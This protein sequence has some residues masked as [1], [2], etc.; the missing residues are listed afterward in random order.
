MTDLGESYGLDIL[1]GILSYSGHD[2]MIHKMPPAFKQIYGFDAV[3]TWAIR[4]KADAIIGRFDKDDPVERFAQNHIL[5]IA[6][7][8]KQRFDRIPNITGGYFEAGAMAA[9]FFLG[10]GFRRFAFFGHRNVVWSE[11]RCD[12]YFNKLR[13]RGVPESMLHVYTDDRF[14]NDLLDF[15]SGYTSWIESLPRPIAVFCCDDTEAGRLI[16]VC[17]WKGI[18]VPEEIAVLGVD[19]NAFASM[20]CTPPLSSISLD[21][22]EAARNAA[23]KI[24]RAVNGDHY[25]DNSNILVKPIEVVPRLSSDIFPTDDEVVVR[26]L[27]Y[28][29]QNYA[30]RINVSD[31]VAQVPVSRRVLEVRF[32]A[33]TGRSILQFINEVRMNQF[34]QLLVSS[35]ESIVNLASVVGF[36]EPSNIARVFRR[37]FGKTPSQYRKE[38]NIQKGN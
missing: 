29:S 4:W 38:K 13:E 2:W 36:E 23:A 1:K 37:R 18:K 15:D 26:A 11:E 17:N 19:D 24:D 28:I 31:V 9:D 25:W 33:E 35:D 22:T 8:Y 12:G 30:T 3:L 6:Q 7:D 14:S 5:A 21:V 10:K 32:R 20:L 34:A 16:D 27:K